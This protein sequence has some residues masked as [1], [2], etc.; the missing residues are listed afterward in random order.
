MILTNPLT[1]RVVGATRAA[2]DKVLSKLSVKEIVWDGHFNTSYRVAKT[3]GRGRVW[4]VG[5]A[6][7]VHSPL[8]GRGM[9]MGIAEA[10]ALAKAVGA[11]NVPIYEKQCRPKARKWVMQ[12]Y[13]L[14]QLM[15]S[16]GLFC[17]LLRIILMVVLRVLSYLLGPYLLTKI[18]EWVAAVKLS[19]KKPAIARD[20]APAP[21]TLEAF[22]GF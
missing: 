19:P 21:S 9:N 14:S 17:K 12:N 3:Y 2:C 13:L 1:A 10:V 22:I 18:I 16:R 8:G 15:F 6:A 11:R 20:R 7:H 5:D 4:L